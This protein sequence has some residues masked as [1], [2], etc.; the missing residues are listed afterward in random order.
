MDPHFQAGSFLTGVM[1]TLCF[2]LTKMTQILPE[3][4]PS[5]I[6]TI[7]FSSHEELNGNPAHMILSLKVSVAEEYIFLYSLKGSITTRV[8]ARQNFLHTLY[9]EARWGKFSVS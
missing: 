4:P 8:P 2:I 7:T 5:S 1:Y 3:E 9:F 6:S